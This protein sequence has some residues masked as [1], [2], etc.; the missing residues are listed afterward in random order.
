MKQ[1]KASLLVVLLLLMFGL[2]ACSESIAEFDGYE[3]YFRGH[4][5]E[6]NGEYAA[7][8][9]IY[10][11]DNYIKLYKDQTGVIAFSG[12]EEEITWS[13]TADGYTIMLVQE[14]CPATFEN[15]IFTIEID[16]GIVTYLADGVLAP[17]I[18]TENPA[19]YDFDLTVP[20]GKYH[21]LTVNQFDSVLDMADFYG[22]DSY[23][24]LDKDGMG[25]ICLGGSKQRIAWDLDGDVLTIADAAGINSVGVLSDGVIVIDYMG[26]GIQLAFAKTGADS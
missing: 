15:G 2:L 26:G 25:E 6:L 14:P 20:Y 7:L 19:D 24:Q 18:P 1:I 13:E 16:G 12:D 11:G 9:D 3:A 23:L 8:E 22:N 5:L 17:E 10:E 4:M 21:G